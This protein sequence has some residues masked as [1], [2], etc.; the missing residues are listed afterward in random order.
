[1]PPT[2][3][4][5]SRAR[6]TGDLPRAGPST[7]RPL[8]HACLLRDPHSFRGDSGR[9]EPTVVQ[10]LSDLIART[11]ALPLVVQIPEDVLVD[12]ASVASVVEAVDVEEALKQA[13]N[14]D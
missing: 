3:D 4:G 11:R 10:H 1:M 14:T 9:S 6:V 13:L 12:A 5:T 8:Q 7:H 2:T